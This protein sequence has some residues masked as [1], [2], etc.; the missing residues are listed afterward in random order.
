MSG[1][2]QNLIRHGSD[3]AL[4]HVRDYDTLQIKERLKKGLLRLRI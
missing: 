2:A 1:S 4:L 3:L